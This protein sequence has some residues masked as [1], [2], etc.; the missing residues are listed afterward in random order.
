MLEFARIEMGLG[1][2]LRC[3]MC[4]EAAEAVY[5]PAEAI[6]ESVARA[7]GSSTEPTGPNLW[8]GGPEP[9][10]HPE[11]PGIVTACRKAGARRIAIETGGAALSVPANAAGVLAAGVHHLHVRVLHADDDRADELGGRHGR[12]RDAMAGVAAYLAAARAA[13]TPVVVAWR[14]PVCRHNVDAL[15]A[16]VVR[17]AALGVNAVRLLPEGELSSSAAPLLASACDTGM[18][19]GVWVEADEVLPLPASHALHSV[20]ETLR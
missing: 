4:A 13:G 12:A 10:S 2:P 9:F 17:A 11:L 6:A 8:L 3:A 19:S 16:I 15:S 20:A 14:V 1:E 7:T 5:H 18:V